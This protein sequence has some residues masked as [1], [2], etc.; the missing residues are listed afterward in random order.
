MWLAQDVLDE[1]MEFQHHWDHF[2]FQTASLLQQFSWVL[3]TLQLDLGLADMENEWEGW[4]SEGQTLVS[5]IRN[6]F[7]ESV[8]ELLLVKISN[9]VFYFL[10]SGLI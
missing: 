5:C 3:R 6:G 9:Q 1:D 7:E 2:C 10:N 4:C 8:S